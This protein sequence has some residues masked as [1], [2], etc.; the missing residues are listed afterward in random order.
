MSTRRIESWVLSAA[1]VAL[2]SLGV[3]G[4]FASTPPD[5]SR[6]ISSSRKLDVEELARGFVAL[7]R[8][9]VDEAREIA[10]RA[11]RELPD[12]PLALALIAEVKLHMSDYRGA[13][14]L[15]RRAREAGAPEE[16]LGSAGLAE[17]ARI[18]TE[19]YEEVVGEHFIVRHTAGKDAIL[20][21]Y[22]LETAELARERI[23]E[24]LG[25]RP[26]SRIMLELYPSAGTLAQVSTLT[27][28]EIKD[29]GTIALCKWNRLMVTTPRAVMFGYSWRDTIAHELA[30][31]L[32]GGASANTVPIWLH[33]GIAKFAET[34]WRSTPGGGL[35]VEQQLAL[36]DAARKGKLIPFARMHPSMA[37][38]KSQEETSL[39][40]AEVHTFIEFLVEKKGWEGMR[41]VIQRMRAGQSD[42]EAI[43]S[44]HGRSL[45]Q[46]EK[47][48]QRSL[49][50][51]KIREGED[52][53][54]TSP[55]IVVKDRPD[56]PDDRLHGV[57]KKGRRF[58]R[59]ADLLY[60]RG[61]MKAAQKELEK[62]FK[63]TGSPMI[64]AKLAMVALANGE[65]D[66]AETAAR[67]AAEGSDLAGPSVTLAEILVH[68]GKRADALA[69]LERAIAVNPFDPRIH[70]LRVA[71]IGPDGD[72][73]QLAQ[74]RASLALV[75]GGEPRGISLG[76]GGLIEIDALPFS[77]IFLS[78]GG[79]GSGLPTGLTTPSTP[80][81]LR[82]GS[83][84]LVL[85]P[86]SGEETTRS[87][88]VLAKPAN[89][90]P[91]RI[92]PEPAGS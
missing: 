79:E 36:R 80:L 11:H 4:A 43:E 48:W 9:Q 1:L 25:W 13:S 27:Q 30:H 2:E 46:L 21:P 67:K 88:T 72:P 78:R 44:V 75:Q 70:A 45:D 68:R 29:S 33:E 49:E 54:A 22:A 5:P 34:A 69:A 42:A 84:T 66:L 76:T 28:K 39:A 82:P 6:E 8:W 64:S 38:L 91:Q 32:I 26:G 23:G 58:A 90:E 92:V 73:K 71:A 16:L 37:K 52:V 3:S 61:R 20:V 17:Q 7:E 87:I 35:S 83:W 18:A 53:D 12:H 24:L 50:K 86:P 63:E 62:A 15:F 55:K 40:F 31:L 89:G 56:A 85:V 51:R 81:E 57:D 19:G 60:A 10:E 59:A 14:E 47:D 77:R 74:A 65:L 41:Q